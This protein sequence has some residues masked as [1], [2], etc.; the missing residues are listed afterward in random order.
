MIKYEFHYD[1]N[2]INKIVIK[3]HALFGNYGNDIICA[4]VS[5]MV[6]LTINAITKLGYENNIKHIIKDGY[7]ELDVIVKDKTVNGLLENLLYSL[8]D[9]Q[10]QYPSHLKSKRSK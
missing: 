4:S 7:L 6:I 3:G 5:T 9:L 1:N 2:E 8:N 10:Q